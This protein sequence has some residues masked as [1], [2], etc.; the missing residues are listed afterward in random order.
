MKSCI[1][2]FC[3]EFCFPF[4]SFSYPHTTLS[5][6]FYC[7]ALGKIRFHWIA[8]ENLS[9]LHCCCNKTFLSSLQWDEI[10]IF[11]QH[12]YEMTS[13]RQQMVTLSKHS[14]LDRGKPQYIHWL[15]RRKLPLNPV[16][17]SG[18]LMTQQEAALTLASCLRAR[19]DVR[20]IVHMCLIWWAVTEYESLH[21]TNAMW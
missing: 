7:T 8:N 21:M 13:E 2:L 9:H 19:E 4:L 10:Q 3:L 17:E 5:P 12:S 11:Q 18:R 16:K 14:F 20:G 6:F 1:S 15:S